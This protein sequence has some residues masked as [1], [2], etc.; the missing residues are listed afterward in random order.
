MS[1]DPLSE[2]DRLLNEKDLVKKIEK[3]I[4]E[5]KE[6]GN[7]PS[8]LRYTHAHLNLAHK[9]FEEIWGNWYTGQTPPKLEVDL[10]CIF[11][12]VQKRIDDALIVAVEMKYFRGSSRSSFY[13]GLDQVLAL[14]LFGFDGLSLWHLFSG[15]AEESVIKGHSNAV[16]EIT[17]GYKLPLFYLA[18]KVGNDLEFS[19]YS[20][21]V[22][23]GGVDYYLKW[24]WDYSRDNRNPLLQSDE[25]KKR[26]KTIKAMLQIP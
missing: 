22:T 1:Q 20:P 19:S 21:A 4:R 9:G 17:Q 23:T 6:K 14:S 13:Q 12:D 5:K 7:R 24:M 25:V 15:D 18:A 3:V 2:T 26:R 16:E 10:L 11:E 8:F